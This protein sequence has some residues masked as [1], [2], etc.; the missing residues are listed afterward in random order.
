MACSNMHRILK[1]PL[2]NTHFN[3]QCNNATLPPTSTRDSSQISHI[4]LSIHS[5]HTLSIH[6][7]HF[8][9]FIGNFWLVS[10]Y[11]LAIF[12]WSHT[13][14]DATKKRIAEARTA[15]Q[16]C[17]THCDARCN[18]HCNTHFARTGHDATPEKVAEQIFKAQSSTQSTMGI[19]VIG[20]LVLQF[21]SQNVL[22]SV[23][24]Q[25]VST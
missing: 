14:H 24:L 23:L 13:G 5:A 11:Y 15:T 17:N 22:R 16:Y 9:I 19:R 18:T 7:A 20:V 12:F 2:H 4:T 21:V 25:S 10:P 1:H 6:S 3:A 8:H